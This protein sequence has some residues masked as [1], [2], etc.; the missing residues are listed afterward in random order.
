[1]KR[2]EFIALMLSP[3]ILPFVKGIDSVNK[4]YEEHL[5]VFPNGSK[6]Y[7]YQ[8]MTETTWYDIG[9]KHNVGIVSGAKLLNARGY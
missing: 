1:M 6:V 5:M 8:N 3:L 9:P 2:S 7:H 4:H